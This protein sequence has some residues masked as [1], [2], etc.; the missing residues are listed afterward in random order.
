MKGELN[1]SQHEEFYVNFGMLLNVN[2][3]A[4]C[5]ITDLSSI[6]YLVSGERRFWM[7]SLITLQATQ[8]SGCLLVR[9]KSYG[10]KRRSSETCATPHA[11][12]ERSPWTLLGDK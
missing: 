2:T 3:F 10:R 9:E 4:K 7:T 11:K 12:T 5:F 8:I 1:L 6:W